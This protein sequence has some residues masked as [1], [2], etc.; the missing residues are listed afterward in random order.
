[1]PKYLKTNSTSKAGINYVRTIVES[2]NCIF[3]KIDQE[4]DV[5][6]DALIEVV[7]NERPTG[8]FIAAQI[9]SENP[10]LTKNRICANFLLETIEII[11][12]IIHYQF[13][14]LCIFPN[15]KAHIGLILN[16]I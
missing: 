15:L 11:G 9:K 7:K 13:T 14:V 10:T 1:M 16:T 12:V 3:Q 6:I 4:N 2:H 8:N 5:G